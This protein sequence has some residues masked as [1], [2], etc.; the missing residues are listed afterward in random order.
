[1]T[2]HGL[3][4]TA[5]GKTRPK[6][7]NMTRLFLPL[8][9]LLCISCQST[10]KDREQAIWEMGWRMIEAS[11]EQDL[12][13]AEATFDSL[14][15]LTEVE[16][17]DPQFI[18]VGLL[19]KYLQGKQGEV[20]ELLRSVGEEQ[21]IRLCEGEVLSGYKACA[22]VAAPPE[23]THPELRKRLIKLYVDD[24]YTR[25]NRLDDLMRA[26]Q[27]PIDSVSKVSGVQ[28]DANNREALKAIIAEYGFPTA[29]MV[30]SEAMKGVFFI[31]QHADRDPEWQ[32]DQ[33]PHIKEAVDRGDLDAS[34]YAYLYDRIQVNAGNPQRYG[35]QFRKVDKEAGIAELAEVE[36]PDQLDRRRM[37]MG[38][39]PIRL[40]RERMLE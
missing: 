33:L 3:R 10:E 23:P 36:N 37:E 30:G 18:S 21:R 32:R 25:G 8:A 15:T 7:N 2:I 26:Y 9:V 38:M 5:N 40:Y 35:S 12:A 31:I 22:G 34:D 17:L 19:M 27:I 28:V 4:L 11:W 1:M 24:Q 6:E 14:R 39:M 29:K 16:N 20:N 13:R